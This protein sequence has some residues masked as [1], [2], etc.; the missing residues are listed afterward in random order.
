M[1]SFRNKYLTRTRSSKSP[2]NTLRGSQINN[3]IINKSFIDNNIILVEE[4][5]EEKKFRRTKSSD[6]KSRIIQIYNESDTTIEDKIQKLIGLD[7]LFNSSLFFAYLVSIHAE[8]NYMFL[9]EI[10]RLK[11]FPSILNDRDKCLLKELGKYTSV[12][13]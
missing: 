8:E 7:N 10:I 13:F 6:Y 2:I 5:K 4:T 9:L 12:F 1:E 11:K 3:I